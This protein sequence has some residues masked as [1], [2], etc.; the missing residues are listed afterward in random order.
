MCCVA[1]GAPLWLFV[2]AA[3]GILAACGAPGFEWRPGC[4]VQRLRRRGGRGCPFTWGRQAFACSPLP[5]P[6]NSHRQA[7]HDHP[8]PLFLHP[9]HAMPPGVKIPKPNS[10]Q[11]EIAI[12][13]NQ[14]LTAID[15]LFNKQQ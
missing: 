14:A 15:R 4:A 1:A 12:K 5:P 7:L 6:R 2:L 8:L 13:L 10:L 9:T 3:L 11:W